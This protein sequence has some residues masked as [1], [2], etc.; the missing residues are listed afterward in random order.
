MNMDTLYQELS[1]KIDNMGFED[2]CLFIRRLVN[3]YIKKHKPYLQISVAEKINTRIHE[4]LEQIEES[5]E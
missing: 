5:E 2:F 3:M 1:K 4:E